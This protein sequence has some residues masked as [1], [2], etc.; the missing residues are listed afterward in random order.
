[1][2]SNN[3]RAESLSVWMADF[4]PAMQ[5]TLFAGGEV[6]LT[7]TG[8]SM[9]PT[10]RGGRDQVTLAAAPAAL[11]KYDLPLYRRDNG[12]FVLHRIIAV[13]DDGTYTCCGDHQWALE[14]GIRR[15]QILALT[16]YI[17]RKGK[18]FPVSCRSYRLWVRAWVWARPIRRVVFR[19][20]GAVSK[21][22]KKHGCQ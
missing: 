16:V 1:M 11:K 2:S 8:T 18:R 9:V 20:Y 3:G 6:S 15:E 19:A 17:T 4:L 7:I 12:Q 10:I 5:Q 22:W 21:L 14:T 13:A